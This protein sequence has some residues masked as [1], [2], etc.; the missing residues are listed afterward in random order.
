MPK[1]TSLS[2]KN[3]KP[4]RHADGEGLYLLV[5]PT[6]ARSWLL[7]VQVDGKR[8][9]IGLGGVELAAR[10]SGDVI[11]IPLL[12]RK[13]LTLSEARDKAGLLRGAAK[14]GLD[15][16]AERDRERR[17]VPIFRV[18][19]KEAHVVFKSGLSA[20]GGDTFIKSLEN[21]TFKALGDIR[22][23][24][25]TAAD[26]TAALLPIWT[27]KPDMARKVRQRIGKVL[28]FAHGKGWRSTEAPGK[29]VSA[30]LP[31]QPQGGNYKAMP[32]A[33]VPALVGTLLLATPTKGRRAL[34]LHIL[35][36]ARPGEVRRARWGQIDFAKGDWNR[37]SDIM[38]GVHASAHTVTLSSAA[39]HLLQAIKGG[40]DP[41]PDDLIFPGERGALISDMTMTKVLRTAGHP[42]DVH[43][44]RSSFRDWA[45]EKM[46]EIPDPVAEAAIAHVVPDKV[47]RAYKRTNF[48]EMRRTLLEAWG[49]FVTSQGGLIIQLE[50]LRA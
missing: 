43:A 41:K 45:A 44:F 20:K 34:L 48:L 31:R 8:R 26:I 27:S 3:S 40:A 47:V 22:V 42:Y 5:K 14:A 25:I 29:S 36:A 50:M 18:A 24:K 39:I 30:G 4:G 38:K 9:D 10:G 16:V 49:A 23:D 28:N 33:D 46:P 17:S 7:R 35:T 11:D 2:V 6:G 13:V 32:Y 37:P 21:H 15:P 1:L 19:A 12:H